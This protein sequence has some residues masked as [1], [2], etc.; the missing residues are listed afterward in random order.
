MAAADLFAAAKAV[1]AVF[2]DYGRRDNRKQARTRHM[3][4]EWGVDKFR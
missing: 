3:L 4:A 1:V 2:R